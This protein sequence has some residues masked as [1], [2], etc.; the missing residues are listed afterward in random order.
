ME[1]A[2]AT[3][4]RWPEVPICMKT[5]MGQDMLDR[6]AHIIRGRF[7]EMTLREHAEFLIKKSVPDEY[8]P[9]KKCAWH[10]LFKLSEVNIDGEVRLR[11][12]PL[13]QRGQSVAEYIWERDTK[14][15]AVEA[16]EGC[17]KGE[18]QDENAM[19]FL[20]PLLIEKVLSLGVIHNM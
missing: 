8:D 7:L 14:R 15:L 9:L 13:S 16:A 4:D 12:M 17:G 10:I 6:R 20:N 19:S 3:V 1:T 11:K 2:Q 5:V 18:P